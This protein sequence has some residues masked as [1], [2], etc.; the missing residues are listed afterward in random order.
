MEV[1][2]D[3]K[4]SKN[5]KNFCCE[6]CDFKCSKKGDWNRHILTPKHINLTESNASCDKKNIY[7]CSICYKNYS[8]RNGLWNHAKKCKKEINNDENKN[9][10]NDID[11]LLSLN[12]DILI[13]I[14]IYIVDIN[15]N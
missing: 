10:V 4:T 11:I 6:I 13:C 15:Y 3:K 9:L 2:C 5:I 1:F 7:T 8:S 14:V 12:N